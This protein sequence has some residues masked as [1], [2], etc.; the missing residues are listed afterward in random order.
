MKR[1]VVLVAGSL[2]GVGLLALASSETI[3]STA[4]RI[5]RGTRGVEDVHNEPLVGRMQY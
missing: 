3:K 1:V 4:E 2:I 5:A